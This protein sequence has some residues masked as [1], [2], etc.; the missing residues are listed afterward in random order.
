ML[1]KIKTYIV[2]HKIVSSIIGI[3]II[4]GVYFL[5]KGNTTTEI[6]YVTTTVQKGTVVS[7]VTGTGQVEAS[8][9]VNLQSKISG[10]ITSVLAKSGATVRKGQML[11]AVDSA[12]AEKALRNAKLNLQSAEND[13]ANAKS[14]Y[15]NIKASQA[16]SLTSSYLT[17]NSDAVAVPDDSNSN[18]S[19]VTLSG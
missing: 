3:V 14:D 4:G 1:Q 18:T 10:T 5:L 15:E 17:L 19:I 6:R 11:F 13:L 9:T 7:S 16:L 2:T 12:N 8:S